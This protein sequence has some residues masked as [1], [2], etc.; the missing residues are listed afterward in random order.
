MKPLMSIRTNAD[1]YDLHVN[2][3]KFKD[4]PDGCRLRQAQKDAALRR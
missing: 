4:L 3:V 2:G 1:H